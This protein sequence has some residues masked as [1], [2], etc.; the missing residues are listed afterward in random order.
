MSRLRLIK[1]G[2]NILVGNTSPVCAEIIVEVDGGVNQ[3]ESPRKIDVED[4]DVEVVDTGVAA[5]VVVV[6]TVVDVVLALA[7][8]T[9]AGSVITP[10]STVGELGEEDN[11][12]AL[13]PCSSP[14]FVRSTL[15]E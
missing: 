7:F 13:R 14:L 10:D 1:L 4:G 15:S 2:A 3:R 12:A 9:T 8:G 11:S 5:V 6:V